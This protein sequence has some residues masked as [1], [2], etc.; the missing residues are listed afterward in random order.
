MQVKNGSIFFSN[1]SKIL[2]LFALFSFH[3]AQS[4][5]WQSGISGKGCEHT[6]DWS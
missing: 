1:N 6:A 3:L 5:L 2:S 4:L